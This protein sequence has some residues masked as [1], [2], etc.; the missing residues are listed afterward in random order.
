[1]TTEWKLYFPP[2]VHYIHFFDLTNTI[3]SK[4]STYD[5]ACPN[6]QTREF[7]VEQHVLCYFMAT[8]FQFHDH[9]L[10]PPSHDTLL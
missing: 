6:S 7:Y 2:P 1:M 9:S 3:A 8:V 4:N 5:Y 10:S